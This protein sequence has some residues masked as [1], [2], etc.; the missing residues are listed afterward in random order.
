[1]PYVSLTN[2]QA[3]HFERVRKV[4]EGR[5]VNPESDSARLVSSYRRALEEHHLDPGAITGPRILTSQ[6]LHDI[7]QGEEVSA[8][9]S[10]DNRDSQRLVNR[11]VQQSA[12]WIEDA[13]SCK[14]TCIAGSC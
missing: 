9:L 8:L 4:I 10:P 6:E 11:L 7:R 12:I 13:S 5:N 2:P 14:P 3:N 1:M